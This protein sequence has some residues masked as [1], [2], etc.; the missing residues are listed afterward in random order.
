MTKK[1]CQ[2]MM[3]VLL[4]GFVITG[5]AKWSNQM[6]KSPCAC[7]FEHLNQDMQHFG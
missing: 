5:C 2:M 1:L 6:Q 3:M 4:C 7:E